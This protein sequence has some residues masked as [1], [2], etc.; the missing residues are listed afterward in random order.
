LRFK[1]HQNRLIDILNRVLEERRKIKHEHMREEARMHHDHQQ[2]HS[3]HANPG[4]KRSPGVSLDRTNL[5]KTGALLLSPVH[6]AGTQFNRTTA[7]GFSFLTSVPNAEGELVDLL[8]LEQ[9]KAQRFA[10]KQL[11]AVKLKVQDDFNRRLM[12]QDFSDKTEKA[13]KMAKKLFNMR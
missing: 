11:T 7:G 4:T 2:P 8:D 12:D 1:H 6:G 9:R 3:A 13:V 10:M 5:G